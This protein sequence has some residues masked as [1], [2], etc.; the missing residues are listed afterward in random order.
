ML[1]VQYLITLSNVQSLELFASLT[2]NSYPTW[3]DVKASKHFKD[4]QAEE[5]KYFV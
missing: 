4:S 1:Y 3:S 5:Q 2:K